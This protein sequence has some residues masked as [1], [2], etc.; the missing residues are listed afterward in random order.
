VSVGM[1]LVI[2]IGFDLNE[3][4]VFQRVPEGAKSTESSSKSSSKEG[5]S[6]WFSRRPLES[7]KQVSLRKMG[8][9]SCHGRLQRT[10]SFA[11]GRHQMHDGTTFSGR[12]LLR[13]SLE[14]GRQ[15]RQGAVCSIR[16]E[17]LHGAPNNAGRDARGFLTGPSPIPI[18]TRVQVYPLSE[19]KRTL[20]ELKNVAI[21]GAAVLDEA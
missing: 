7:L 17:W 10:A 1:S 5:T 13:S 9:L 21:S 12:S 6:R 4:S 3:S 19:A 11:S 14:F 2:N 16:N 20:N 8:V 18:R 15:L